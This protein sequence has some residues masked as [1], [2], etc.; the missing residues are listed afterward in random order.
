MSASEASIAR[1]HTHLV[2]RQPRREEETPATA[3]AMQIVLH[4]EKSQPPAR[5]EILAA[6]ARACVAACLVGD[7]GDEE[8]LFYRRLDQWYGLKIRKVARRAHG[9]GWRRCHS[10]EGITVAQGQAQ[11]RAFIPGLVSEVDKD[12]ARLQIKGTD[13]EDDAPGPASSDGVLIAIDQSLKMSTGKAAAQVGHGSMLLAA[14]MSLAEVTRWAREGFPLSVRD[15]EHEDFVDLCARPGAVVVQDAGYT[16][17]SPGAYT[18]V[19]VPAGWASAEAN[20]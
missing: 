10:V 12:V 20:T 3:R 18:V 13:L 19:A 15:V 5:S 14:S 16:E 4:I 2:E 1:A 11:A 7:A 17:V 6:A 9:A 8:S